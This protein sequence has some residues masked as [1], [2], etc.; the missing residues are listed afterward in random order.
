[1]TYHWRRA[2]A[3]ALTAT[4]LTGALA[5]PALARRK[6][7]AVEIAVSDERVSEIQAAVDE[8]RYADASRMI[9]QATISGSTDPR[10]MLLS[11]ELSLARGKYDEALKTFKQVG[12]GPTVKARVHQGRGIALSLL[13][14]SDEALD[15]LKLAV[16]EDPS[17]WRA[18]NA[19]GG[20]YDRRQ[21]WKGAEDAYAHALTASRNAAIVL[22]NRGFSRVLQN[23]LDEGI[24]DLVAALQKK[25]DLTA[26]RTNLRLAMGLKGDYDRALAAG[27]QEDKAALLNNVGYAAMLRGDNA[28]AQELFNKA[29]AARGQFY[30]RASNNLETAEG[31]K[32]RTGQGPAA[33]NA[34][35]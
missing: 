12:E 2:A 7:A 31:L 29:I 16:A 25:P 20:E 5:D 6:A 23:R 1:M 8:Q 3:A 13:G 11:G 9:D 10:I 22:N 15:V 30:G 4:L 33:P 24:T 17:A 35:P 27:P 28:Q 14:K 21:D 32:S 34:I 26:A 18:W 19:L